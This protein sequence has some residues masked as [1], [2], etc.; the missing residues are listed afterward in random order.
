MKTQDEIDAKLLCYFVDRIARRFDMS[1]PARHFATI[2]PRRAAVCPT[3]MN[4]MVALSA[5][6]MGRTT[7]LDQY[8]S[9]RYYDKCIETLRPS[10]Y[11]DTALR[12]EN[13]FA[14]IVLLRTFEEVEGKNLQADRMQHPRGS[15][16]K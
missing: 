13:L 2:L 11:D 1:D 15:L 4:A 6:Y 9:T 12:D 3:L 14:A 7:D 16:L 5:R 8:Y 10:L